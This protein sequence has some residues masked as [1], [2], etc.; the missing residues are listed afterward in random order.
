MRIADVVRQ[1]SDYPIAAGL[2]VAARL[3]RVGC[4]I[5]GIEQASNDL[6]EIRRRWPGRRPLVYF[7]VSDVPL[8]LLMVQASQG[9]LAPEFASV[10]ADSKIGRGISRFLRMYG[11]R[12]LPL[13]GAGAGAGLADVKTIVR[14]SAPL[15]ISADGSGPLGRVH[16]GLGRLVRARGDLAT[17]LT[18]RVF[19]GRGDHRPSALVRVAVA[20]GPPVELTGLDDSGALM[21]GLV[22]CRVAC[23]A[24]FAGDELPTP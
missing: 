17:P 3:A 16:S 15:F 22:A 7:W 11:R 10:C 24:R 19:W 9:G 13:R 14:G 5:S 6:A 18:L 20:I 8:L 2:A 4:V 1:V 21:S 12:S 23:G